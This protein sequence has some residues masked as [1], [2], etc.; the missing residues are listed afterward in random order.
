M[1]VNG[2]LNRRQTQARAALRAAVADVGLMVMAANG[3]RLL[4][5]LLR[6]ILETFCFF[7]SAC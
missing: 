4:L 2:T 6:S 3:L 1:T 7:S 5:K